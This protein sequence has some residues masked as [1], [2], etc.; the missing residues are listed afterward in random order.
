MQPLSA[1]QQRAEADGTWV[2]WDTTSLE[3]DING[4]TEACL[5][6]INA[7]ATEGW[8]RDGLHDDASDGLVR[9]V[10]SRCANTI[11]VVH[12][13]GI[14][15]VDQW[16]DHDN[17][18]AAVIAH[19]PGQDS[20]RALVRLLYGEANFSGKL[21]YTL[22]R[23]ESDYSV[24]APCGRQDNTTSPQCDYA[25]GV[26]LDYRA[27]DARKVTPRFEFGFGLSYTSFVFSSLVLRPE[28]SLRPSAG[29]GADLWDTLAEVEVRLTND[30]AVAGA[31]VAQLYLGI[32]GGPPKQLRGFD[33]VSLG[34][35]QSATARFALTRRDLSV[36][37]VLRQ[38]WVV[39]A[40]AY[41]VF[42]GASSRDIRL[43]ESLVV[44]G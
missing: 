14:R 19:L 6:F 3:P 31:E 26:Y 41:P 25:E 29:N 8:D 15:L 2:N 16:I 35:G 30:G 42:V 36:W 1:I 12:A 43:T 18:T 13:A 7:M 9:H 37:D 24:Y 38:Q 44:G 39:Q 27:F 40:G 4:A 33:K 32:P 10:A 28:P 5:V 23:N 34:P 21:P 17:V 20:G 11:V 22:A